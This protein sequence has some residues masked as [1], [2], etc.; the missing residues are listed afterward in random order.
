[1]AIFQ[2]IVT[3]KWADSATPEQVEAILTDFTYRK[4]PIL[5]ALAGTQS[6]SYSNE[7]NR[8]EPNFK[9]TFY[10]SN[11]PRLNGIKSRYDADDIFI[12]PTGVGSD[13]WDEA[14]FCRIH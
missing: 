12:V 1:M 11:Y 14:G 9:T 6:G 2:M 5:A 13:R 4:V 3:N 8:R 7:G 10:G